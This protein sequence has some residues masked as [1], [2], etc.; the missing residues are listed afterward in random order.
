MY[1]LLV[2]MTLIFSTFVHLWLKLSLNFIWIMVDMYR[3]SHIHI[4]P[5]H[6]PYEHQLV[7][8]LRLRNSPGEWV[9]HRCCLWTTVGLER[10]VLWEHFPNPT[11]SIP[12]NRKGKETTMCGQPR[13]GLTGVFLTGLCTDPHWSWFLCGGSCNGT[14]LHG[15]IQNFY[16]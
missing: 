1:N 6:Q 15:Y 12:S 5:S 3:I 13:Q 2:T 4:Y 8:M 14:Q 16:F 10:T 11:T 7:S 9:E